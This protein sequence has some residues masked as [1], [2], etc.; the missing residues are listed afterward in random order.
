MQTALLPYGLPYYREPTDLKREFGFIDFFCE[1]HVKKHKFPMLQIKR[2]IQYVGRE[3]EYLSDSNGITHLHLTTLDWKM[4]KEHYDIENDYGYQFCT[5]QARNDIFKDIIQKN[6][7]EKA[8]WSD[9]AHYDSYKRTKAKDNTNMLYGSFGLNPNRDLVTPFINDR[10]TVEMR[11]DSEDG[12]ARYI[13]VASAITAGARAI[14]IH[15][16]DQ[17]YD[18]WI[19][20]DTDSM[21]LTK[22]ARGLH[23]DDTESGAWKMEGP[24]PDQSFYYGKFLRQ[25]C[26]VLADRDRRIYQHTDKYGNWSSKCVC[27]GMPDA[28]KQ[29]VSYEDFKLGTEFHKLQHTLVKGGVCLMEHPY[30]LGEDLE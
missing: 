8:Y 28:V 6:I 12:T 9:K 25:K 24:E 14:T 30:K 26:Y 19:Y 10:G 7:E 16:I 27:A 1:F 11:H 17:N 21:Y 29:T 18:N 15:A 13:P 22:R 20:S 4:M 2:N 23:V 3:S 5:F